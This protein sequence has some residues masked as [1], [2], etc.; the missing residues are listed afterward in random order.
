MVRCARPGERQ[1]SAGAVNLGE[2]Q[3]LAEVNADAE[4]NASCL[5][6]D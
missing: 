2:V 6:Q 5:N 1:T 3:N 4:V